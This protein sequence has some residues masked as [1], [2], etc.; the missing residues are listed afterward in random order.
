MQEL[1]SLTS[2]QLDQVL[3]AMGKAAERWNE[4][5]HFKMEQET[6]AVIAV[7]ESQRHGRPGPKQGGKQK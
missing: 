2:K 5:R 7:I 3:A 6:E 1:I 4:E